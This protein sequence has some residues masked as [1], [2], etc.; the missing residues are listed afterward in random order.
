MTSSAR[1]TTRCSPPSR[2]GRT[3][4][5]PPARSSSP[6]ITASV[7]LAAVSRL[8]LRLHA[9]TVEGA[10]S[11]AAGPAQLLG[12]GEGLGAA[13]RVDDEHVDCGCRSR[14]HP[15]VVTGQ[16][17]PVDAD[18]KPDPRCRR[19]AQCFDEPVVAPASAERVLRAR[20]GAAGVLE[21]RPQVVVEPAHEAGVECVR[22]SE[23]VE[24]GPDRG[25]VGGRLGA[26][27]IGA[28]G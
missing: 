24:S 15:F 23:R 16:Q 8:H 26:Q 28:D 4:A 25:E 3:T 14:E 22:N 17:R 18:G 27:E 7:R 9:A 2:S 1:S 11:R 6:M 20:Q 21:R 13:C 5:V 10:V 12:D 19:P